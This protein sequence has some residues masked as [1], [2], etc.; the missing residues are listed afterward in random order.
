MITSQVIII[1]GGLV[2]ASLALAL[3]RLSHGALAVTLVEAVAPQTHQ[4]LGFDTRAMALSHRSCQQL[5]A[6]GLWPALASDAT[7]IQ[8]IHLSAQGGT[9]LATLLAGDH[10]LPALG[11][12][13]PAHILRQ[14]LSALLATAPGVIYYCPAQ[15]VSVTAQA[16]RIEVRLDTG[17]LLSGTLL[18]AATGS[19]SPLLA[20]LAVRYH[21]WDYK[22]TAVVTNVV[23]TKAHQ[24][25]AFER[26]TSH[27]PLALLPM[28]AGRS[29]MVWCQASASGQQ[30][31]TLDAPVFLQRLQ[32]GFGWRLGTLL[33]VERRYGYPL[34]LRVAQRPNGH[35]W[36]VIGNA[37]QTLHPIAGQGFNL[38][39]QDVRILA[40][41]LIDAWRQQ[42]D[43][44]AYAILA[45]YCADR[46]ADQQRMIAFTNGLL[47]LFSHNAWPVTLWRN[48][49]LQL[50]DGCPLVKKRLSA[51]LL[52]LPGW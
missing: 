41:L 24:G 27:G 14:Q 13:V 26:F 47:K 22:Q 15:V 39:L 32:Q 49:G 10:Q 1:G 18:V 25:C 8:S 51:W 52:G 44:G 42:Q 11:H 30:L 20:Q 46:Q 29:A 16:Q 2:G 50:F 17:M 19:D 7:A 12:V 45:Q 31:L 6:M 37:A 38:A 3:S 34:R 40:E 5:T 33:Q 36:V 43:L 23:S 4:Q 28:S 35:R 9:G 48:L 21:T